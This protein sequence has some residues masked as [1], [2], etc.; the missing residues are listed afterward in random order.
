MCNT[1]NVQITDFCVWWIFRH[2][3]ICN[4]LQRKYSSRNAFRKTSAHLKWNEMKYCN[5]QFN[6]I[7][8]KGH[9]NLD[10]M[11]RFECLEQN[12]FA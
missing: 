11:Y 12:V 1:V 10:D 5:Q 7:L 8:I 4:C 2:F 3:D 6:F 9:L